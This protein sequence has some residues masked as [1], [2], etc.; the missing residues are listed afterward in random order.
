VNAQRSRKEAVV[1]VLGF[2]KFERFFRVAGG[3]DVDR[4]DVKRYLDFQSFVKISEQAGQ[5]LDTCGPSL[6][7]MQDKA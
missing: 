2:T 5:G 7:Y 3:V 4:D 6:R 1:A